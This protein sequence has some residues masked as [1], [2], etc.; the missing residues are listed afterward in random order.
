MISQRLQ[1]PSSSYRMFFFFFGVCGL[2][3]MFWWQIYSNKI[4]KEFWW[5]LLSPF[6]LK[7]ILPDT[8]H[9]FLIEYKFS[10]NHGQGH[11][12]EKQ[13]MQ[14]QQ[15][16]W[17]QAHCNDWLMCSWLFILWDWYRW[18]FKIQSGRARKV[19][20]SGYECLYMDQTALLLVFQWVGSRPTI[21]I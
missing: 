2:N 12:L 6:D 16:Q 3:Q 8:N 15:E 5:T 4:K 9:F 17:L 21:L 14:Q 10:F 1:M 13:K 19:I 18:I 20:G 11:V 7:Q